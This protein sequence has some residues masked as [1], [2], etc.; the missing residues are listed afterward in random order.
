MVTCIE[1]LMGDLVHAIR[2]LAQQ[3]EDRLETGSIVNG[4]NG[5]DVLE[6][7]DLWFLFI[8][9]LENMEEDGSSALGIC[10]TFL[11]ACP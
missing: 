4:R 2:C 1:N 11:L 8:Y 7:E 9:I 10:E 6:N 3:L 5:L